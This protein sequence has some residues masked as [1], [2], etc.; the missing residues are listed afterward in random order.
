MMQVLSFEK[1]I[2]EMGDAFFPHGI[3]CAVDNPSVE[4]PIILRG[5][6]EYLAETASGIGYDALEL[7]LKNPA[8]HDWAKLRSTADDAG[9]KYSA[10][11]TGREYVENGLCLI[12]D[13]K[14]SRRAAI[15]RLKEHIDMAEVLGAMV[16][17]G[18]MRGRIS[19]RS[20]SE[21]DLGKLT[22]AKLELAEYAAKKKVTLV[23]ENILSSISNY[24]NTIREVTNYV[25]RLAQPN[26]RI[27]LDTYSM[28]MEDND[29]FTAVEYC[30]HGL[31]YVHFSD[32]ARLFP[33]GGNVDFKSFVKALR[34]VGYDKYVVV[35]CVPVPD[36]ETCARLCLQ[37]MR[38]IEE[39]VAVESFLVR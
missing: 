18:T 14:N 4:A 22:D 24:L 26:I 32:S 16:V 5:D 13:D 30:A 9:L 8:D 39:C 1:E 3:A 27:H 35:E 36:A 6:I 20:K 19:D 37:Y 34:K 2:M 25:D 7:H 23:V 29:I 33:G 31:E 17:V 15:E 12:A 11:A 38:A 21:H 10:I 28:L